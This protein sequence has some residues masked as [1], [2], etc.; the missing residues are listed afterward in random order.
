MENFISQL[1]KQKIIN[2]KT[3]AGCDFLVFLK[4]ITMN[5]FPK[6]SLNPQQYQM[7]STL[8]LQQSQL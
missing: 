5:F 4:K 7:K 3:P 2:K 6:K 8:L 1:T